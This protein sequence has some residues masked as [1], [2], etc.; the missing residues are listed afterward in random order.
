MSAGFL[1]QSITEKG[2]N[3]VISPISAS[4]T[5]QEDNMV[6]RRPENYRSIVLKSDRSL[7]DG[8]MSSDGGCG[9]PQASSSEAACHFNQKQDHQ[10]IQHHQRTKSHNLPMGA[11]E[12]QQPGLQQLKQ[13]GSPAVRMGA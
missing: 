11:V 1:S 6:F 12:Q 10:M 9:Q 8:V 2:N 5:V 3:S 7:T 4:I 13:K